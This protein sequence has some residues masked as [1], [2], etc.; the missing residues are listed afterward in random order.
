[1]R[2]MPQKP[3]RKDVLGPRIEFNTRSLLGGSLLGQSRSIEGEPPINSGCEGM[4]NLKAT[5]TTPVKAR[6]T[7]ATERVGRLC[8]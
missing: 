5:I 1:M 7:E 8:E 2:K 4:R 6:L 3:S